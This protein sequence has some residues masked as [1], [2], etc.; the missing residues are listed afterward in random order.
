MNFN[1]STI[2]AFVLGSTFLSGAPTAVSGNCDQAIDV[3]IF[4]ATGPNAASI[5]GTFNSFSAALGGSNNGNGS[6][7]GSPFTDGFRRINWDAPIVPFDVS[8]NL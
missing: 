2:A 5:E 8:E 4:R 3:S 1:S 6:D 7:N